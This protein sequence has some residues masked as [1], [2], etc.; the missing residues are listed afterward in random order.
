MSRDG[1]GD[2]NPCTPEVASASYI[3]LTDEERANG[4]TEKTLA[5]YF[6]EREKAQ[7]GVVL[8]NPDYRKPQRAK[9]ANNKYSPM[10]WRG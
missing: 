6:E 1:G 8:F 5:A 7:A 3:E 10:R 2:H 9:W 4:W